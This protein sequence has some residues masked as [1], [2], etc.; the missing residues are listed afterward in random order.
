[1]TKRSHPAIL[2]VAPP[3]ERRA[4]V[5]L[6][7]LDSRFNILSGSKPIASVP[8]KLRATLTQLVDQCDANP[9]GSQA[10]TF[11]EGRLVR[12]V[13]MK[14][15]PKTFALCIE[16]YAPY[17]R[18][19]SALKQ[20]KLSARELDVLLLTLE[21]KTTAEIANFLGIATST[22]RDYLDKLLM[23]TGAR[24]KSALI[25]LVLGWSFASTPSKIG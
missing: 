22:V 1:M 6:L 20:F 11:S 4:T 3:D 21:G 25:A 16:R 17:A 24:N 14:T 15:Y 2:A 7:M 18:L 10:S 23:K 13:P 12:L 19:F 9:A 5:C 8:P